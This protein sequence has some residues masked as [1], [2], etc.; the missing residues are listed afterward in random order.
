MNP[1]DFTTETR[2]HL[3]FC[4]DPRSEHMNQIR[5]FIDSPVAMGLQDAIKQKTL[6]ALG[7]DGLMIRVAKAGHID[8]QDV[9]GINFG[10]KGFLMHDRSHIETQPLEFDRVLYPILHARADIYEPQDL[11]TPAQTFRGHAFNEVYIRV[12]GDA[13]SLSLRVTHREKEMNLRGDGLMIATPA[14]STG[15]SKSYYG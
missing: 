12:S 13:S 3:T 8:E 6:V 9:L 1:L 4:Y 10:S 2:D 15:W 11:K 7:G 5:S 14:G